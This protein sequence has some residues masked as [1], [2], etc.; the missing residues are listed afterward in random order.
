LKN[1][2]PRGPLAGLGFFL[3]AYFYKYAETS[4]ATIYILDTAR[5]GSSAEERTAT[6]DND[7]SISVSIYD[8][9]AYTIPGF[10][11]LIIL[12][13]LFRL[14]GYS[15]WDLSNLDFSKYWLPITLLAYLTGQMLD[16]VSHRLW[17]KFWFRIPSEERAYKIFLTISPE[18]KIDFNP[19]QWPLL[20]SV[21]RKEDR[22]TAEMIDRNIA[23]SIMLRNISFGLL[24]LGLLN[25]YMAFQPIF[26]LNHLLIALGTIVLSIISLQRSDY[27]N[28]LFYRT[29]FNQAILYGKNLQEILSVVRNEKSKNSKPK[30]K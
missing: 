16:F 15:Y 7:M 18:E 6:K 27:F 21:I 19:K 28:I 4:W 13:E 24:L 14:L 8:L 26:S 11:Y 3:Y 30:E 17:I 23:I 5:V 10:L 12:N 25:L 22:A 20:F 2:N 9:F 29:V 1:P